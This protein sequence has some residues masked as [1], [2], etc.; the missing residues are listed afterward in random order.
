MKP[1]SR[2]FQE[3]YLLEIPLL[4][5]FV[6]VLVLIIIPHLPKWGMKLLLVLAAGPVLFCLH[7]MIVTPGWQPEARPI[8]P[9]WNKILFIAV[10]V[11][12][13]VGLAAFVLL[14]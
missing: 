4:L 11:L 9:P 7:Y 10:A 1:R 12:L 6:L 14:F 8:P 13:A 5:A 2:R 3:G